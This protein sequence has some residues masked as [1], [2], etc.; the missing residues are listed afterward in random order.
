MA[1]APDDKR[2]RWEALTGGVGGRDYAA[3]FATLAAGGRDM[4]G[5]ATFCA[6]LVP[7]GAR[8]LDAG[9][10]TGRVAVRLTELGFDCVGVDVDDSM[11]A[12]AHE[13]AP[14]SAWVRA[15]LVSVAAAEVGAPFDLVVLAGNV[16]PLLAPGSV[17]PA[18]GTLSRLLRPGGV[19]VAGFGLDAAHLPPGC[20]VTPIADYD[21]TC[22]RSGLDLVQRFATWEGQPFVE[23]AG[24]AVSVHRGRL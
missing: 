21:D 2:T 18:V 7:P 19:L 17:E 1:A 4:H 5:E 15:D 23:P 3:R 14:D 20:P 8:V 9:C 22:T 16:V 13:A 10:G 12:V 11:L 24:Y 6:G